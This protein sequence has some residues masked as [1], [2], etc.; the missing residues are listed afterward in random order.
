MRNFIRLV[1]GKYG[2]KI[3]IDDFG[4]GYSNFEHLLELEFDYLKIDG[5]IIS[6]LETHGQSHVLI[7]AIVAFTQKLGIKTVAE[8]VSSKAIF[9]LIKEKGIDFAQGYFIGTPQK[10]LLPAEFRLEE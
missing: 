3:A 6:K 9:D 10:E 4:S 5:S 8:F 2:S 1:K 7:D